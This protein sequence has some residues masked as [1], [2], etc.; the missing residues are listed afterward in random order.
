MVVDVAVVAVV[1]AAIAVVAAIV[2]ATAAVV[3]VA[4]HFFADLYKLLAKYFTVTDRGM[5]NVRFHRINSSWQELHQLLLL[6]SSSSP[7]WPLWLSWSKRWMATTDSK[8]QLAFGLTNAAAIK[9]CNTNSN[10]D[11]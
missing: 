5:P 6:S 11:S 1:V 4:A 10:N 8:L 2:V 3:V 7:S 9:N